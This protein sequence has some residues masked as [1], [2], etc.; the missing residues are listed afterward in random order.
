[1]IFDTRRSTVIA[2]PRWREPGIRLLLQRQGDYSL[3]RL[4]GRE[5]KRRRQFFV[6]LKYFRSGGFWSFLAGIR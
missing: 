6:C 4:R 5:F 1:M 2:G 3:S